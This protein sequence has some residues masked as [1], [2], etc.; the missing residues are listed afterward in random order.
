MAVKV[1]KNMGKIRYVLIFGDTK[2]FLKNDPVLTWKKDDIVYITDFTEDGMY[3]ASRHEAKK[4]EAKIMDV[5]KTL[6]DNLKIMSWL[7]GQAEYIRENNI[8]TVGDYKEKIILRQFRQ[9]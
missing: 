8:N 5:L 4:K 7:C 9:D 1:T 2:G 3:I 6:P